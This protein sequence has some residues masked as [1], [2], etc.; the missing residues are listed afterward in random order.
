MSTKVIE[1]EANSLEEA[2]V[3]ALARIPEGLDWLSDKVI[4]DGT[5]QT[6]QTRAASVEAAFEK[7]QQNLPNSATIKE[8]KVIETP[9]QKTVMVQARSEGK[10][11]KQFEDPSLIVNMRLVK[12]GK[13]GFLGFGGEASDY[14]VDVIQP[15]TVE[16]IYTPKAKIEIT[17]GKRYEQAT[18]IAEG[19][20]G[21]WPDELA[22]NALDYV[23]YDKLLS[24]LK[25]YQE[26]P[27]PKDPASSVA[28]S[29][30]GL[31]KDNDSRPNY[32]LMEGSQ[33][34]RRSNPFEDAKLVMT[35]A[36]MRGQGNFSLEDQQKIVGLAFEIIQHHSNRLA[37]FLFSLPR[38]DDTVNQG[39][40]AL[41]IIESYFIDTY[42]GIENILFEIYNDLGQGEVFTN[43]TVTKKLLSIVERAK[44]IDAC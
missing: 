22:P 16:V 25:H 23:D 37:K 38:A 6:I 29:L 24:L 5:P 1:V 44:K 15:A 19:I 31:D 28:R 20:A 41:I 12:Q 4:S 9:S 11:K 18:L 34:G 26:M 39:D 10:V 32:E 36:I 40:T 14:E 3:L 21:G 33:I 27:H 7:A 2:K 8:K 35:A 13:K 30:L 43:E 17:V 42:K